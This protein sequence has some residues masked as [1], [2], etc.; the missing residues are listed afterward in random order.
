MANQ[1]DVAKMAGVSTASVS[2]YLANPDAVSPVR[3]KKI[4]KAIESLNY[5]V[6]TAAQTMKTGKTHH[7]SILV[8]GSAP[9]YWIIIQGIQQRLSEAGY[10]SSVLFTREVSAE[11]PF[12]TRLVEKMVNSNQIEAYIHFPLRTEGDAELTRRIKRLHDNVLVIDQIPDADG[13]PSLVFDNY[14]AGRS[15]AREMTQRGH[16]KILLLKGDAFFRS[17]IERTRGFLDG[18]AEKGIAL[19]EDNVIQTSYTAA[20]AF[21]Q[22]INS[23]LPDFTAV[24]APNDTTALAFIKAAKF[25]GLSCPEDFKII[26]FDNNAEY[27]PYTSPSLSSFDQPIQEAGVKAAELVLS[28]IEGVE[29]PMRTLFPL[30]LV[31]RESFC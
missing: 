11:L 20:V 9:F 14:G 6:D 25:K 13:I 8:P 12:N 26:S 18:L 28:M 21:P 24:L 19:G 15:A 4:R 7:I 16:E 29:I 22:F 1:R 3:G 5:K 2:R 31:K 27:T 23:V 30:K 10:Y 17:S